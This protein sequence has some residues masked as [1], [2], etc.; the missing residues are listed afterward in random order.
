MDKKIH[1]PMDKKGQDITTE[2]SITTS[3]NKYIPFSENSGNEEADE[4]SGGQSH[5]KKSEKKTYGEFENVHLSDNEHEKL[6]TDYG[7]DQTKAIIE[8]LSA[9][10]AEKGKTYKSDMAAIRIWVIGSLEIKKLPPP[11]ARCP[12]CGKPILDGICN[13]AR[14]PQYE[15]KEGEQWTLSELITNKRSSEQSSSTTEF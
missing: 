10:K 9:Y 11:A 14:C 12:H 8:K 6:L 13:N 4:S 2:F 15:I 5:R 7:K 3:K 1:T